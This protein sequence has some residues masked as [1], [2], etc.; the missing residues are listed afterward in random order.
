[1]SQTKLKLKFKPNTYPSHLCDE[2]VITNKYLTC[3]FKYQITSDPEIALNP[4][5][6]NDIFDK[7]DLNWDTYHFRSI[8]S[9]LHDWHP[10]ITKVYADFDSLR[11]ENTM[12]IIDIIVVFSLIQPIICLGAL[13][14]NLKYLKTLLTQQLSHMI[15]E[16]PE[17]KFMLIPLKQPDGKTSSL[18]ATE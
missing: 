17:V 16:T 4:N 7:Y 5:Q 12:N 18:P 1:M 3:R 9:H 11:D 6:I 2:Y 15:T 8:Q 10:L 13:N 14:V